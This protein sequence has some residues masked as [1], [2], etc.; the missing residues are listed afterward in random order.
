MVALQDA[1]AGS[2]RSALADLP[3]KTQGSLAGDCDFLGTSN[4]T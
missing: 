1:I 3:R 2:I 4:H